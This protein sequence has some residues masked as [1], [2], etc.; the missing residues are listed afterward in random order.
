[1]NES[2]SIEKYL[3]AESQLSQT[4]ACHASQII[5]MLAQGYSIEQI[6]VVNHEGTSPDSKK[7]YKEKESTS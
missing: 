2:E 1:L 3:K 6:E 5:S 7:K 4:H